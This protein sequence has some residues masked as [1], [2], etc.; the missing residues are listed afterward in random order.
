MLARMCVGA[1]GVPALLAGRPAQKAETQM[2]SS[3]LLRE[4]ELER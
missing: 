4:P 2:P 1:Y 3:Q